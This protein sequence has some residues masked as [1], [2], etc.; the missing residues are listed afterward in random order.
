MALDKKMITVQYLR[1]TAALMVMI[2]HSDDRILPLFGWGNFKPMLDLGKYGVNIFFFIS[3]LIMSFIIQKED[4]VLFI[5]RRVIR[6]YPN[7]WLISFAVIILY[8]LLDRLFHGNFLTNKNLFSHLTLLPFEY[9]GENNHMILPVAWSLYYEIFFYIILSISLFLKIP[10]LG[11]FIFLVLSILCKDKTFWLT[12][13]DSNF[14]LEFISGY[15]F[16]NFLKSR[17]FFDFLIFSISLTFRFKA[18][19]TLFDSHL[20]V[21]FIMIA[22][23]LVMIGLHL[24]S[25]NKLPLNKLFLLIGESSYS[26]YLLHIPLMEAIGMLVTKMDSENNQFIN[27]AL[28]L[29]MVIFVVGL[30]ILNYLFFEKKFS[31]WIKNKF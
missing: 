5:K 22:A 15:F 24:E 19:D 18:K 27:V 13:F 3:G 16:M 2:F 26:L 17:N 20:S 1:A 6:I 8:F 9:R 31:Q 12:N 23:F 29:F 21:I 30:S 14:F 25:K 4:A 10:K 28:T 11:I 7:Y